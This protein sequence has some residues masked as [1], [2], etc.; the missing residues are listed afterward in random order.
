M[1]GNNQL[2]ATV[3]KHTSKVP[4][5]QRGDAKPLRPARIVSHALWGLSANLRRHNPQLSIG[6]IL[7]LPKLDLAT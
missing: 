7:T 1:I 6:L 5:Q 3:Q 2:N 4:H